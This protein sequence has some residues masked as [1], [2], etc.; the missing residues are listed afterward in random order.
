MWECGLNF[1]SSEQGALSNSSE[2]GN[3]PSIS[4]E[5]EEFIDKLRDN[6]PST[7]T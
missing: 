6:K 1:S 5:G 4:T 2:S 7:W 3:E